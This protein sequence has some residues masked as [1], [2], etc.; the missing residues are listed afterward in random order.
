MYRYY[1]IFRSITSAQFALTLMHRRGIEAVLSTAPGLF[2]SNGCS[3]AVQ[4]QEKWWIRAVSELR[5]AGIAPQR[6]VRSK[7]GISFEEVTV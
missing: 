3:H 4:V 2:F 1:F 5:K 6:S 7:D